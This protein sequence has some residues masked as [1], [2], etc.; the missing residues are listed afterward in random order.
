MLTKAEH[1]CHPLPTD[2]RIWRAAQED[3]PLHTPLTY[4]FDQLA[5]ALQKSA[6]TLRQHLVKLES[7]HHFPP[8]L[9]VLENLWSRPAVDR[10]IEMNG[11]PAPVATGTDPLVVRYGGEVV[12]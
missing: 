8:R 10:W 5:V 11:Q 6:S 3:K 7:D 9:P 4:T 1:A 12:Q 2:L